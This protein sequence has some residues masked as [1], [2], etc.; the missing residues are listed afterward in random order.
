MSTPPPPPCGAGRGEVPTPAVGATLVAPSRPTVQELLS[1]D[2]FT[3]VTATLAR[4]HPDL[5]WVAAEQ[6]VT[7][8]LKFVATIAGCSAEDLVPSGP[9]DAAWHALISNTELYAELCARL[10]T[11]VHHRPA[12]TGTEAPAP[13]WR[14]RTQAA[15]E[16]AGFEVCPDLW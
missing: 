16:A 4:T 8:A 9:V 15:I 14:E 2:D 10:G 13:G 7:E 3:I 5:G 12:V 11:F 6:R 1:A